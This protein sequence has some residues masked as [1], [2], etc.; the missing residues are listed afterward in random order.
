[1]S[2]T[3]YNMLPCFSLLDKGD[4]ARDYP[5]CSRYLSLIDSKRQ[6]AADFPDKIIGKP[7]IGVIHSLERFF[8]QAKFH[9]M[10]LVL[11]CRAPLNIFNYIVSLASI[12][13]IYLRVIMGIF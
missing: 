3:L 7:P 2:L 12:D 10:K 6:L 13:M 4:P 5:E 1:M 8:R 11:A 9:R